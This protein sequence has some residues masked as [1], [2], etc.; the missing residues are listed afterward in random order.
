MQAVLPG[1]PSRV[2]R[3]KHGVVSWVRA[4]PGRGALIPPSL[5][6]LQR[7][8]WCRGL[9]ASAS[10]PGLF[11]ELETLPARTTVPTVGAAS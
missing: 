1:G 9:A 10:A 8:G 5:G 3:G 7:R 11:V 2:P 6:R 4:A